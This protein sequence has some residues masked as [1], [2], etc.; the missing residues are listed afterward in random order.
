VSLSGDADWPDGVPG[1]PT[2]VMDL[3]VVM[4]G[5]AERYWQIMPPTLP[6]NVIPM[7][8]LCE[9]SQSPESELVP[10]VFPEIVDTY[11]R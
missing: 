6:T 4:K 8:W 10:K 11:N 1:S 5:D 3:Q 9:L 7:T 2:E